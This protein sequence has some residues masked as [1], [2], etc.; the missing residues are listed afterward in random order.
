MAKK[1]KKLVVDN[2]LA[3]TIRDSAQQIW[4]AGLGAYGKA[5][6]EGNKVFDALVRE[7]EAIQAKTRKV[8]EDKVSEM[9]AKA[10]GTWDKLEQVFENRVSKALNSLGVPT[11]SDIED[12]AAR[13]AVLTTEV[14]KLNGG[15]PIV[16]EKAVKAVKAAPKRVR[17]AAEAVAEAV[18]EAVEAAEEAVVAPVQAAVAKKPARRSTKAAK[19]AAAEEAAA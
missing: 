19:P 18:T 13:V 14:E 15:T 6:E 7:G 16:V 9:A 11:K 17:T 2:Q 3:T 8:A 4:L 10:T 1:L 12:L 5:Q